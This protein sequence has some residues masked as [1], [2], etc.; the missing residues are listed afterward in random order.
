MDNPAQI[1]TRGKESG[2]NQEV[3]TQSME[4]QEKES[5]LRGTV[6]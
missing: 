5:E 6:T 3:R 4:L 2:K 1:L